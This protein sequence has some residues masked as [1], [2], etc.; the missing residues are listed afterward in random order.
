MVTRGREH[1][2]VAVADEADEFGTSMVY[3]TAEPR[4]V[5]GTQ[6]PHPVGLGAGR[7]RP[8]RAVQL[9]NRFKAL[10]GRPMRPIDYAGW[11]AVHTV[12]EGRGAIEER[13][14]GVDPQAGRS[15]QA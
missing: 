6:G 7:S 14:S 4:P 1:D 2:V 5:V 3:N 10:A 15:I 9:Q 11:M 13:R 12:G 8:G